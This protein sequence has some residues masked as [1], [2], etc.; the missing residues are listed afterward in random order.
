MYTGKYSGFSLMDEGILSLLLVFVSQKISEINEIYNKR[1]KDEEMKLA[2]FIISKLL[3]CKTIPQLITVSH[4]IFP[5]YLG[6]E[7]CGLL[8]YRRHCKLYMI[9]LA[10]ELCTWT[11]EPNSNK[12]K[13]EI[14]FSPSGGLS[15]CAFTEGRIIYQ[16]GAKLEKNFSNSD[17]EFSLGGIT[18]FIFVPLYGCNNIKTGVLQLYNKKIGNIDDKDIEKLNSLKIILGLAIESSIEIND[19]LDSI[20][21]AKHMTE[22]LVEHTTKSNNSGSMVI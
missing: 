9:N 7:H 16:N 17:N 3:E 8:Y 21:S 10:N 13:S 15:G 12:L 19:A 18:S 20:L 1:K 22:K 6:Y 14:R 11:L 5:K 4:K 2:I